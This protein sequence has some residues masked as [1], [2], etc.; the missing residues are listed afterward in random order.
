M[1]KYLW[2]LTEIINQEVGKGIKNT[3]ICTCHLEYGQK[4]YILFI[5]LNLTSSIAIIS[6]I[7][8]VTAERFLSVQL[9]ECSLTH[10]K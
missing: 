4:E 6:V 9:G 2:V 5:V 1:S 7:L 10:T 8:H 3:K